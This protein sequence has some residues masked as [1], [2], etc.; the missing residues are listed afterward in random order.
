MEE[1]D[2]K[3]T[4]TT[5]GKPIR[6]HGVG[7]WGGPRI[8]ASFRCDDNLWKAFVPWAG[9]EYGSICKALESILVALM[10]PSGE[11]RSDFDS[12]YTPGSTR[13]VDESDRPLLRVQEMHIHRNLSRERR[14][15][16]SSK[17]APMDLDKIR[18]EVRE[19]EKIKA[20]REEIR[21]E[22]KMEMPTEVSV[23][24]ELEASVVSDWSLRI[25]EKFVS[26]GYDPN[27]LSALYP[28]FHDVPKEIRGAVREAVID[29]LVAMVHGVPEES[30]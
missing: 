24:R 29:R 15:L 17:D 16:R 27:H 3:Q 12:G 5:P 10:V 23:T 8:V 26:E 25:F 11:L 2:I 9:R 7:A 14:N 6:T 30:V 21:R 22:V 18:E 13:K 19:Q 28:F 4:S 1:N 20:I